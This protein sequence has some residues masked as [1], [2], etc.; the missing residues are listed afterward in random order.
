MSRFNSWR[1][2][3]SSPD[4]FGSKASGRRS[5]M[6]GGGAE[7][8][9]RSHSD[10]RV[11]YRRA[12]FRLGAASVE[13]RTW[14]TGH[15]VRKEGSPPCAAPG[16]ARSWSVV[17][18]VDLPAAGLGGRSA[19]AAAAGRTWQATA[20]AKAAISRA[21]AAVTRFAFLPAATR[22]R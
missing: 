19:Q 18:G 3:C 15:I 5:R 7:D 14:V 22:R 9:G 4:R 10:A 11:G 20:Q 6:A 1:H 12:L 2:E 17:G 8:D 21:T 13:E 16:R